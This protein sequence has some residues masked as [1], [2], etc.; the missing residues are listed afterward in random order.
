M[1]RTDRAMLTALLLQSM[2]L[3]Y[4]LTARQCWVRTHLPH[5]SSSSEYEVASKSFNVLQL[6]CYGAL[7]LNCFTTRWCCS[8]SC[9]GGQQ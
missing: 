3:L 5:R 1:Q 2:L 6:W 9:N 7:P 4:L 8:L